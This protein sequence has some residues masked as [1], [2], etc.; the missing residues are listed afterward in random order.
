MP[1][2]KLAGKVDSAGKRVEAKYLVAVT[3]CNQWH[4][5]TAA[6]DN[7]ASLT[8]DID[9][10]VF[11]DLSEDGT[12]QRARDRGVTVIQVDAPRG[13]TY[14]WNLAYQH[15]KYKTNHTAMFFINNDIIFPNDSFTRMAKVCWRGV[16][17]WC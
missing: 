15:F 2:G 4:L 12:A 11:D 1:G 7:L 16:C 13:V 8:D 3:T 9:V 6:L 17:V 5:S 10:V 14:L